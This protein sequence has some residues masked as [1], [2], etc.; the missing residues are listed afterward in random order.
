MRLQ[1]QVQ[2]A[3]VLDHV[4]AEPH[5]RQRDVGLEFRALHAREQ[6]QVVLV[7]GAAQRAHRPQRLAAVEA[8]RAE[9]IGLREPLQH[10]GRK[11]GAQPEIAHG[12]K[13]CAAR[14]LRSRGASSSEKPLIWRKPSRSAWVARMSSCISAWR[15]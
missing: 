7:A 1:R 3:I 4:L 12:I 10:G 2:V 15:G 9:G 8:E 13:A 5:R 6:R 11:P 14:A